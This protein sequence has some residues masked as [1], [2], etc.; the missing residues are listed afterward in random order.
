MALCTEGGSV[1][2]ETFYSDLVPGERGNYRWP[3]RFD[4]SD[5]YL[6]INSY[7]GPEETTEGALKDR[8]LLSPKQVRALIEFYAAHAP[9]PRKKART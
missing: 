1:S 6:G 9:K 4:V 3:A 8:V 5:G 2:D 7:Y